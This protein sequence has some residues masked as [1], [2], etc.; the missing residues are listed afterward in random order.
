M[1]RFGGYLSRALGFRA[2][3]LHAMRLPVFGLPRLGRLGLLG[4]ALSLFVATGA[5]AQLAEPNAAGVAMGHLH[6]VVRDV[7]ANKAFWIKLGGEAMT[8]GTT[9]GVRFP[10]VV[11][12]LR[13]GETTA[14]TEGSVVNH[15]AFRVK[16]L[17]AV[18]RA[19][20]AVE[21][22]PTYPGVAS[23][24]TPEGERIELFDDELATNLTFTIDGGAHDAVVERHNRKIDVPIIAHHIHLNVPEGQVDAA[25]EWYATH[26]GGVRGK[27][28][29]YDAVDLPGININISAVPAAQAPTRGRQLDHIGFEVANLEAFCK[30]LEASGIKLDR[31]YSK[32]P[33]GLGLAFLTDPWGTYIE[34]TE[35]LRGS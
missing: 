17:A 20:I 27:R 31:P 14:G 26:F 11:V 24:F 32:L 2:S 21:L 5:R 1:R 6:Y 7:A 25:K 28:W 13:Q 3:E 15:V 8:L 22:N 9:D 10:D 35:G 33:S 23:V 16:S 12:L 4:L 18:E 30:R 19:G 34:L 29:R